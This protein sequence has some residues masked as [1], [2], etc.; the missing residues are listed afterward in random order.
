RSTPNS[1]RSGQTSPSRRIR[2]RMPRNGTAFPTNS[3]IWNAD[4]YRATALTHIAADTTLYTVVPDCRQRMD[5]LGT[6]AMIGMLSAYR[7]L[8]LETVPDS[9]R[10][11]V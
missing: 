4:Q 5:A 1:A 8:H 7:P 6:G 10:P 2:C 3:S 9:R 11:A